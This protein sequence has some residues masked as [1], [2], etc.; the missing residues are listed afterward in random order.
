MYL[1]LK[2]KPKLFLKVPKSIEYNVLRVSEVAEG[3]LGEGEARTRYTLLS[4]VL[5]VL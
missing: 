1:M 2:K 5:S 3:D 4:E